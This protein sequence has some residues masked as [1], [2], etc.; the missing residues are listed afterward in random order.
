MTLWDRG[1]VTLSPAR[2]AIIP[3]YRYIR[4]TPKRI[5]FPPHAKE[6]LGHRRIQRSD[7][8][9]LL[10]RGLRSQE[11][12]SPGRDIRWSCTGYLGLREAKVVFVESREQ[13]DIIT[14][15]WLND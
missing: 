11:P 13:I 6:R 9:W 15:I 14:V 10:A 8:R 12:S 5:V 2:L 4:V 3:V 7:V 1:E